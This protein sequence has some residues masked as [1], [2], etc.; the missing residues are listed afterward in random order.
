MII[1]ALLLLFL[2]VFS[3]AAIRTKD[4]LSSIIILSGYSLIMTV[5][6]TRLNAVDVAFTEAS[7]GAGISTVIFLAALSRTKREEEH[8]HSAHKVKYLTSSFIIPLLIV[9]ITGGAL[10]Y[11]TIDM[12][13]YGDP[14]APAHIHVAPRYIYGSMP[15]MGIKNFVTTILAAYRGY[16]TLGETTVIFTAG[17]CVIMLLRKKEK[18]HK[19]HGHHKQDKT[20]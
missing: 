16:D 11:G 17:M 14:D 3:V 13:N 9:I 5:V 10:A 6:W 18:N 4:L 19:D 12:P 2:I 8:N 15:E 1:D 20:S 7:V